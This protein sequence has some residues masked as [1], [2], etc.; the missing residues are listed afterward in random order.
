[1]KNVQKRTT[2][3]VAA[4]RTTL[5]ELPRLLW[6]PFV[7]RRINVTAKVQGL[8][9]S[10][11]LLERLAWTYSRL[12]NQSTELFQ[13]PILAQSAGTTT[14]YV[15]K[16][17]ALFAA[18]ADVNLLL[19]MVVADCLYVFAHPFLPT[20]SILPVQIRFGQPLVFLL[21]LYRSNTKTT[22]LLNP[23]P[24]KKPHNNVGLSTI[25]TR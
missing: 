6:R 20:K 10:G 13:K 18:P 5:A 9:D 11:T 23:I 17:D 1:M 2:I 14:D 12:K 24:T 4:C 19:T 21:S 25:E 3:V 15:T 7:L 16:A 8:T 22:I